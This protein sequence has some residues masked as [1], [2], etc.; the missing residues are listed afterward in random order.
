MMDDSRERGAASRNRDS[1]RSL[2]D[3]ITKDNSTK[4]LFPSKV[5]VN[6]GRA[7]MDQVDETEGVTKRLSG[8]SVS[9]YA[10]EERDVWQTQR[11]I[12]RWAAIKAGL[13][14]SSFADRITKPSEHSGGLSIKGMASQRTNDQGFAIKGGASAREL[15]PDKLNNNAGKELF[16]EKLENRIRPRRRAEDFH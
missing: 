15:F 16:S 3:R 8:M 11:D 12:A 6:V 14:R 13:T 9:T 4:E 10:H 7:Q 1:A 2:K 5:S